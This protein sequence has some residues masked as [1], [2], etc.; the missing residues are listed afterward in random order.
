MSNYTPTT[1]FTALTTAHDVIEGNVFD[2]EFDNIETAVNSKLDSGSTG[3]SVGNISVT[4]STVPANGIYLPAANTLGVATNTTERIS[5]NASG[6]VTV[7][8]PTAG[9]SVTINGLSGSQALQV[10]PASVTDFGINIS[11]AAASNSAMEMTINGILQAILGVAGASGQLIA[12]SVLNDLCLR[13]VNG[14]LLLASGAGASAEMT[15]NAT[16]GGVT[17]G[18][19]TGGQQGLGTVNSTGL[20]V[21]GNPVLIATSGSF[22]GTLTGFTANPTGTVQFRTNGEVV[23]IFIPPMTATS[24]AGTLTLTGLPAGI[25]PTRTQFVPVSFAA[26]ALGT[27]G[28]GPSIDA[29]FTASSGTI[30]FFLGG[31]SGA[32]GNPGTKGFTTGAT[33]T[34]MLN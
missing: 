18:A 22:T 9:D 27:G 23:T 2:V 12:G 11:A 32:W 34:Y 5:V 33:L 24:N 21:N 8:A 17:V 19:P 25:Q 16:G 14:N 15:I 10:N 26:M 7:L 31:S 3:E 4:S 29:E 20:F 1:N 30:T 6:A 28:T 13:S